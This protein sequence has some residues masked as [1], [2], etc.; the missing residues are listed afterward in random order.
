MR[1]IMA[2]LCVLVIGTMGGCCYAV[3][4]VMSPIT[5]DQ[6]GPVGVGDLPIAS[7][8][9]IGRAKAE[10]ILFFSWGDASIE[11]AARSRDIK[12]ISYVDRQ[13]SNV[14]GVYARYETIVYGK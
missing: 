11:A 2:G 7:A 6:K 9:K 1:W 8:D 10:G 13:V 12:Q 5:L 3:G 4:P 14:L